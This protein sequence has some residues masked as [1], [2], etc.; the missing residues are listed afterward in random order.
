MSIE[1]CPD[2]W[3]IE[4]TIPRLV[5]VDDQF[6]LLG[7]ETRLYEVSHGFQECYLSPLCLEDDG[8]IHFFV[9]PLRKRT[10]RFTVAG[11]QKDS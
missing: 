9:Q 1:P 10:W 8:R 5:V 2:K 11:V 3:E 7:G 4:A 6:D